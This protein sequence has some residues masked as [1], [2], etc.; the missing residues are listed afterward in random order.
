MIVVLTLLNSSCC[1]LYIN[2]RYFPSFTVIFD[3]AFKEGHQQEKF[4]SNLKIFCN[5][6][7]L[8]YLLKYLREQK[9]VKEGNRYGVGVNPSKGAKARAGLAI[10]K[11]SWCLAQYFYV[12]FLVAFYRNAFQG[13]DHAQNGVA[14]DFRYERLNRNLSVVDC[15]PS[16]QF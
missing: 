5:S 3:S 13:G 8:H 12:Y 10:S 1:F 15:Y 9:Y 4:R 2:F 14:D 16:F 11:K 6:L 7:Y